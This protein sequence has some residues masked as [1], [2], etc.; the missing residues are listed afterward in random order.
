MACLLAAT[1]LDGEMDLARI[2]KIAKNLTPNLLDKGWWQTLA[3]VLP[4]TERDEW[5]NAIL[6]TKPNENI[7]AH[8][9]SAI[10]R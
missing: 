4:Q 2:I 6:E 10:G 7:A 8:I 5:L 1:R 3:E 9:N